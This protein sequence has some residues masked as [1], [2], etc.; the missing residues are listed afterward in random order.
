MGEGH[1]GGVED[2]ERKGGYESEGG[3][4]G[5]VGV[6]KRKGK[7]KRKKTE[8]G[9]DHH[10]GGTK[11]HGPVGVLKSARCD[12]F[13]IKRACFIPWLLKGRNTKY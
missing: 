3:R 4:E 2:L 1:G 9:F 7:R 10:D 6:K 12:C 8:P 5:F 11:F 13:T